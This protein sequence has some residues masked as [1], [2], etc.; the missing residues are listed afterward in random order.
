MKKMS[1]TKLNPED[2]KVIDWDMKRLVWD[3]D[4]RSCKK[5]GKIL[6]QTR[7]PKGYVHHI[8]VNRGNNKAANLILLCHSCHHEVHHSYKENIFK[9]IW[10][11]EVIT[12][13]KY[14][15]SMGWVKVDYPS[16][17]WHYTTQLIDELQREDGVLSLPDRDKQCLMCLKA[18]A[19]KL[20]A[21]HEKAKESEVKEE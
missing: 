2:R 1:R 4:A 18:Q 8:D 12:G 9:Y 6:Y 17:Q 11:M 5:C 19:V 13:I 21:E 14:N 7:K 10:L 16:Y 20:L 3:R 15:I